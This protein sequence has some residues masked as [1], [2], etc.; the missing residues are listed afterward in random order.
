MFMQNWGGFFSDRL[1]ISYPFWELSKFPSEWTPFLSVMDEVWAPTKFIQ[2]SISNA[3]GKLVHYMPVSIDLPLVENKGR[4][5]FGIPEGR[6]AFLLTFDFFH[7][8]IV[9]TPGRLF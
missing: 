4:K 7:I 5:N 2:E 8:S 6:F 1:N 9:R 3:L